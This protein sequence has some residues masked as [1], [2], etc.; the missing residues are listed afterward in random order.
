MKNS[1]GNKQQ[2]KNA[3]N[4]LRGNGGTN[5]TLGMSAGFEVIR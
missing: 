4:S 2:L 3:I 5:I 1:E